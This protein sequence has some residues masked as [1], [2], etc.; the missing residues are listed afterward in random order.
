MRRKSLKSIEIES[1]Q[2]WQL[3]HENEVFPGIGSGRRNDE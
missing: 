1:H 2:H 3:Q